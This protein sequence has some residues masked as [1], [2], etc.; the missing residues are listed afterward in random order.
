MPIY[1]DEPLPFKEMEKLAGIDF[2]GAGDMLELLA[3]GARKIRSL[4]LSA[5]AASNNWVVS[6]SR[7][8]SGKP[9][10]ANDTHLPL[11]L[12]SIWMLMQVRS[13]EVKG[14]GIALPGVPGIIA[15]YNGRV[16]SG[17]T[18]VMADNQDLFLEK[19]K[20]KED[21]LYCLYKGQWEKSRTRRE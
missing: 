12:P 18:M 20:K 4:G 6:G 11:S 16:A 7:T 5:A 14:A 10:F 9:I 13:P 3:G 21:G 17:M 2:S 15:G 8:R 19:L 1:P